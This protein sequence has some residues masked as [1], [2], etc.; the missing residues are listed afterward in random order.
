MKV[1]IIDMFKYPTI[2]ELASHLDGKETA[3]E[4]SSQ[5]A[6]ETAIRQ[7][8]ILNA[9]RLPGAFKRLKETRG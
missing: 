7:R 5:A 4:I 2:A 6:T 8:E 1:S 3:A 9:K